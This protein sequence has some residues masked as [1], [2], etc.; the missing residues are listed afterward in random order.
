MS[1]NEKFPWNPCWGAEAWDP[2][3]SEQE[4]VPRKSPQL[5]RLSAHLAGETGVGN[6]GSVTG[7]THLDQTP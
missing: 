3:Q 4:P 6:D 1:E 7:R 5:G 2:V